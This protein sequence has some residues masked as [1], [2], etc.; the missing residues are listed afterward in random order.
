MNQRI[1]STLGF[2]GSVIAA[3]LAAALMSGQARAEGPLESFPPIAGIYTRAEVQ[4]Q[5]MRDRAQVSSYAS[6][7]RQQQGETVHASSGLTRA[8]VRAAYI[9]SREEVRAMG[10][11]HS[12]SGQFAALPARTR[13][14]APVT[15]A[16]AGELR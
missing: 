14:P 15:A 7:W 11:E 9:D 2:T 5:L 4:E 8:E 6:E 16:A 13:L 1:A 3:T 12:G 10:A